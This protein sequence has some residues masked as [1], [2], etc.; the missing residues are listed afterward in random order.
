MSMFDLT[1]LSN[2]DLRPALFDALVE[3]LDAKAHEDPSIAP[4]NRMPTVLAVSRRGN[5]LTLSQ[6]IGSALLRGDLKW[7]D[8]R[9]RPRTFNVSRAA[10]QSRLTITP[11]SIE[12]TPDE[13]LD[14]IWRCSSS[15]PLQER[16]A[17][18]RL[19]NLHRQSPTG[20]RPTAPDRQKAIGPD[21]Q[22]PPP[23][24]RRHA[25]PRLHEPYAKAGQPRSKSRRK[26]RP[27]QMANKPNEAEAAPPRPAPTRG[28]DDANFTNVPAAA[29]D[30]AAG[31]CTR[32][33][34][35]PPTAGTS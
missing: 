5:L 16:K 11:D 25:G 33:K 26:A 8:R 35:L 28:N 1:Q 14:W 13:I 19:P 17:G 21:G 24:R 31:S 7:K 4:V 20:S 9:E 29:R 10:I 12:G 6:G 32:R 18:Q 30:C 2:D 15:G 23:D 3:R 34:R 27:A 22:R